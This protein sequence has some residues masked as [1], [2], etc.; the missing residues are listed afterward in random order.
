MTEI[1]VVLYSAKHLFV[2]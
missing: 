1:I 2:F